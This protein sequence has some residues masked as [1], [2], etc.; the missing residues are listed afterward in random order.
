MP[1]YLFIICLKFRFIFVHFILIIMLKSPPPP[2]PILNLCI[3]GLWREAG[4]PGENQF[5]D[6]ENIHSELEHR[7]QSSNH[8]STV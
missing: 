8:F 3:F 1:N 2:R 5:T 7:L 4:V 6:R